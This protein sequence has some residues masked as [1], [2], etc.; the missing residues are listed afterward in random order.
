[1][2]ME[3]VEGKTLAL[4]DISQDQAVKLA[5][6]AVRWLQDQLPSVPDT[7]FGRISCPGARVWHPFFKDHRAGRIFADAND[8]ATSISKV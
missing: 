1:M 2:V 8:L 5:A 7:M 3:K 4:S 6:T